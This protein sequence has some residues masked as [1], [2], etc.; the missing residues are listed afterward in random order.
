MNETRADMAFGN[1]N[2]AQLELL[3]PGGG[4]PLGTPNGPAVVATTGGLPVDRTVSTTKSFEHLVPNPNGT[5]S[6]VSE[7]HA[8]IAPITLF[9]NVPQAMGGIQIEVVGEAV[10]KATA[11]GDGST[12]NVSYTPPALIKI[13]PP[14]QPTQSI[15]FPGNGAQIP[16]IAIPGLPLINVAIGESP[17]APDQA[18]AHNDAASTPVGPVV[19]T[20]NGTLAWGAL[21][22]VR[23]TLLAPDPTSHVAEVRLGHLE[24]QA[25]APAGGVTCTNANPVTTASTTPSTSPGGSTS[26]T[27]PGGST[28][29]TAPGGSTSTTAPGATTSSSTPGG[30]TTPG[31]TSTTAPGSN[32]STTAAGTSPGGGTTPTTAGSTTATTAPAQVQAVTFS[33]TPA[34]TPQTQTPSFTG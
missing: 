24:A 13:T 31:N 19:D 21:D 6:M 17:R 33:Q 14:G 16:P 29:S 4:T 20:T 7:V 23:V 25:L 11:S 9:R 12:T 34:A 27:T 2:V 3:N 10:L 18:V 5:F 1:G 32:T 28:S 30:G 15:P 8:T 22:V 26:S